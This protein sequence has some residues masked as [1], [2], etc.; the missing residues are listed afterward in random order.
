VS[1]TIAR[2][3]PYRFFFY[4]NE[5]NEPAHVHVQD[6]RKLAKVWLQECDLASSRGFAA[7][8]LARIHALVVEHRVEFLEA[9]NEHRADRE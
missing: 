8:E 9:W 4:S 5:E 1:P 6:G 3:G 7:H 2:I